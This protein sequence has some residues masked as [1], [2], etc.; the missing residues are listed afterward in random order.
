M[1]DAEVQASDARVSLSLCD[2]TK[3]QDVNAW[4]GRVS[5]AIGDGRGLDLLISNAGILTPGP[6]EVLPL[7]A[8][9]REFDVNVF[10]ALSVVNAFCQRCGRRGPYRAGQ[11]VDGQSSASVQRPVGRIEGRHGGVCDGLSGRVET[12][13][14]RRRDRG[15]RQHENGR[16]G[17]NGR[18]P[19]AVADRMTAEQRTLYGETFGTF[20]AALNGMQDSGLASTAAASA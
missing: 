2:I 12:R 15:R 19:G 18:C 10:G 4:S 16:S 8:I 14:R 5:A 7:D 17:K 11:H 20:T 13:R 3:Q 6:L 1:N 9:R